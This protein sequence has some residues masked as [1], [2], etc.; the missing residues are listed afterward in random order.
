MKS[1]KPNETGRARLVL[2]GGGLRCAFTLGILDVFLQE[3]IQF[4][5]VRGVSAGALSA[6]AFC[7]KEAGIIG[8]LPAGNADLRLIS[9][10]SGRID[11]LKYHH[12]LRDAAAIDPSRLDSYEGTLEFGAVRADTGEMVYFDASKARD[13][14]QLWAMLCASCALPFS[15]EPVPV[16]GVMYFDGGM[17]DAIPFFEDGE[18]DVIIL[19]QERKYKKHHSPPSANARDVLHRWPNM[20]PVMSSRPK[21]YNQERKR[22]F[23]ADEEKRAVTF[24]PSIPAD[25]GIFSADPE[26]VRAL[27]VDGARQAALRLSEVRSLLAGRS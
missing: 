11:M 21:R 14:D 13:E 10:P 1:V 9:A 19:T 12:V 17:A 18:G 5:A 20:R 26:M 23:L 22:A 7:C 2:E 3:G 6:Y 16:N 8:R 25:I 27:Y 15:A 24:C 4:D